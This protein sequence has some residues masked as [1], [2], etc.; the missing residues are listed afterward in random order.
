MN[1]LTKLLIVDDHELIR[2]GLTYLL[3][4]P[5]NNKSFSIIEAS[6]IAEA[7]EK[8]L[9]QSPAVILLDYRL[10]DGTGDELVLWAKTSRLSIPIITLSNYAEIFYIEKMRSCGARGYL[11]KDVSGAELHSAINAVLNGR[12]YFP[13]L[14]QANKNAVHFGNSKEQ[15]KVTNRERDVLMLMMENCTTDQISRKLF[16]SKRTVETHKQHLLKKFKVKNSVSLIRTV[17][18]EGF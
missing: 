14:D 4:Q 2:S 8:I 3:L 7:K 17:S 12:T 13:V 15:T 5:A 16:I 10:K 6:C 1:N 18:I 11:L 9:N